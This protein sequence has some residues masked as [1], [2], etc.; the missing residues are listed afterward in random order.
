VGARAVSLLWVEPRADNHA[1]ISF[2]L[3]LDF[4]ISG[5]NDKLYSN[6]DHEDGRPT[7]YMHLELG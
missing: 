5:F 7:V 2:Y 6:A 4:R 3:S 1:A